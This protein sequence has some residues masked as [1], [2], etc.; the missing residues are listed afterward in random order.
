[1]LVMDLH[2]SQIQGFFEIPVD[3]LYGLEVLLP[4]MLEAID[5][6]R[7]RVVLCGDVGSRRLSKACATKMGV[8]RV[9]GEKERP[10]DGKAE[11]PTIVGD[12]EGCV[13]VMIDDMICTAGT[14]VENAI[15]VHDR[16]AEE[17]VVGAT[18]G[19]FS[20]HGDDQIWAADRIENSPISKV[21]VTDTIPIDRPDFRFG[22][23]PVSKKV[24]QVSV[25]D[26]LG[27]A[28]HNIHEEKSV[29]SLFPKELER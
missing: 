8:R 20:Y 12:V 27:Q 29:S 15:A 13:V 2:S 24:I 16:G 5:S 23:R 18:H 28:I 11:V 26:L 25:A 21:V 9:F 19:L 1:V 17:I 4:A 14:L 3:N 7:E 6:G 22:V 10:K